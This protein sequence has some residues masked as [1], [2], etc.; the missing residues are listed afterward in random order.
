MQSRRYRKK[1]RESRSK[2]AKARW[3]KDRDRRDAEEP[4]RIREMEL[5]RVLGEGPAEVGD[6]LGTLS[7]HGADGIKRKWIVRQ[8]KVRNR[9]RIDGTKRDH[10]WSWLFDKLRKHCARLTRYNPQ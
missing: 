1:I 4:E 7:W 10:G 6:F 5:Q 3:D 9:I 2:A 8:G